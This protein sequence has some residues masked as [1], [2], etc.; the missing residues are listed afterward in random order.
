M[1]ITATLWGNA[2]DAFLLMHQP[3]T[4]IP[5]LNEKRA[6]KGYIMRNNVAAKVAGIQQ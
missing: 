3:M 4:I 2:R 6:R 5:H 1:Q